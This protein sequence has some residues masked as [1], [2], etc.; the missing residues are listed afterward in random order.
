M[1]ERAC[2]VGYAG[3]QGTDPV[4]LAVSTLG[5]SLGESL[6]DPKAAVAALKK[7]PT[8]LILDNLEALAE[9]A[10]KELLDAVVGWSEAGTSRV[11][12]TTRPMTF[13]IRAFPPKKATFV[14]IYC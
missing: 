12:I 13:A 11:L 10:L 6:L 8:L 3:F 14:D 4:G 1:F 5:S 9:G 2:L 7:T